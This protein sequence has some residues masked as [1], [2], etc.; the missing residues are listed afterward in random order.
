MLNRLLGVQT[1][2]I[3]EMLKHYVWYGPVTVLDFIGRQNGITF[4]IKPQ[5]V[6]YIIPG[7]DNFNEA[8]IADFVQKA[9]D[10]LVSL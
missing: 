9:Q 10:N 4:S 2:G 7:I 3:F 5:Q 1:Y 8:N 6:T